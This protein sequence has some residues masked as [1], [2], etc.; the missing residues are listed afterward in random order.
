MAADPRRLLGPEDGTPRPGDVDLV[1]VAI[2]NAPRDL[3]I[4]RTLGWYRIPLVTAPKTV[5]VDWVA[6]YLP[7]SFDSQRWSVRYL[8]ELR[9]V[10]LCTRRELLYLETDHP[11]ADEP[12]FKLQ[13]GPLLE[14]TPPI[15]SRN[16]RRFS[17]LYTT[18]DRLFSASELKDLTVPSTRAREQLWRLLRDRAGSAAW[19][20]SSP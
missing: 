18:G 5:R 3:E 2:L 4:A 9:G 14:L 6:F 8:A 15:P 13:L 11:R 7:G 1:L 10:E 12:Y 20:R 17:F 16:W 19:A